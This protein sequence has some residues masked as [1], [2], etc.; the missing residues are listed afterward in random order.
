MAHNRFGKAIPPLDAKDWSAERWHIYGH[1]CRCGECTLHAARTDR[2]SGICR[3][4]RCDPEGLHAPAEPE[5]ERVSVDR[6]A[7]SERAHNQALHT[8][9]GV[10][11][12]MADSLSVDHRETLT[13]CLVTLDSHCVLTDDEHDAINPD[14][15]S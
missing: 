4:L 9:A 15:A 14:G 2:Y 6:L 10:L 7:Q 1:I 5:P 13:D 11:A 8:L 3:C 12:D